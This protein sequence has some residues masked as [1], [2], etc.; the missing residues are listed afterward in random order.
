MTT[1]TAETQAERLAGR[2]TAQLDS[3]VAMI[4]RLE[5]A[6]ECKDDSQCG[7]SAQTIIEG[8]GGFPYEGVEATQD[9]LED[10]HDQDAATS[11]IHQSPLSV[12]VR[13]GWYSM[14]GEEMGTKE[15]VEYEILLMTGGPAVR[16]RGDLDNHGGPSSAHLE[17]QDWGTPW[18]E[19][20]DR[21]V[22]FKRLTTVRDIL[23]TYAQQFYFGD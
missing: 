11:A 8:I 18:T 1:D 4:Q 14:G 22:E 23:L 3:I 13:S 21:V 12:L 7:I 5:H 19:Y 10:Y 2:A 15:P 6:R 20:L 9:E 17:Y 16:I